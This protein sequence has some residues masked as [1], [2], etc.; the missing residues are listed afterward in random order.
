MR[1]VF[2][3]P[4][5]ELGSIGAAVGAGVGTITGTARN[6]AGSVF[7]ATQGAYPKAGEDGL[8]AILR[9]VLH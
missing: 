8:T 9:R 4:A 7:V 5:F 6:T 1:S 2:G 3:A